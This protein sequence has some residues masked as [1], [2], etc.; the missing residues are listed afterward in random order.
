MRGEEGEMTRSILVKPCG[1]AIEGIF[2]PEKPDLS[3][4]EWVGEAEAHAAKLWGA[5][6][7]RR[8]VL[9]Q[10]WINR[11]LH[12]LR[13]EPRGYGKKRV[14]WKVTTECG[15]IMTQNQGW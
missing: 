14:H 6:G 15:Q 5:I 13:T 3:H 11:T 8:V 12:A 2:Y 1:V 7:E 4:Q 10:K 9:A